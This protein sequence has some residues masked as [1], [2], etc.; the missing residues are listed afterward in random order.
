M[1]NNN[2]ENERNFKDSYLNSKILMYYYYFY[3]LLYTVQVKTILVKIK[4]C[5]HNT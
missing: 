2:I 5:Q 4:T 3:K 1:Y